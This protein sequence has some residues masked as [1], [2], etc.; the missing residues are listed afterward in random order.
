MAILPKLIGKWFSKQNAMPTCTDQSQ[1]ST[2]T[3]TSSQGRGYCG[4]DESFDDMI[5][6]DNKHCKIQWYHLSCLK[7]DKKKIPKDMWYCPDCH[8]GKQH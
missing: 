2:P 6:C 4:K 8:K 5:G 3:D 7:L 1:D